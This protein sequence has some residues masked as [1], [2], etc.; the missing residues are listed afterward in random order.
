MPKDNELKKK[1][2]VKKA[3]IGVIGMGYVGLP[4]AMEFATKG[5]VTI[6]FD[7]DAKKISK[8]RTGESYI[9]YISA[10]QIVKLVKNGKL[11]P[12]DDFSKL[13]I[14]DCIIVCV[15]T[16]LAENKEP[17]LGFIISS[18]GQISKNLRKRQLVVLE[19]TTYPGTTRE[20]VMPILEK[21]GLREGLDF[22]LAFSPE[23]VDPGNTKYKFQNIP[24][25]VGGISAGSTETAGLLYGQIVKKVVP[26]SSAEVAESTKMLE[27]TFRAVNIALVNELKMIFEKMGIN[28]WEVIEAS[29][30][31]PYGFMPFYP[32]PGWGGHCIPIDPFYLSWK[33]RGYGI[34]AN[35]IKL[36]GEINT[37]MPYYVMT[38]VEEGL[39]NFKKKIENSKILILGA[40]YKS[41]I[42]DIRESPSVLLIKI[43]ME[44]GADVVYN[45]P[46]IP[47][48]SG[49][50]K[51]SIDMDSVEL[52]RGNLKNADCVIIA[53]AHKCY[54]YKYIYMNSR[55]IV[56]TRNALKDFRDD[57][58]II[59]A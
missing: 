37:N 19:S 55:L 4:L 56:D 32:G 11:V 45:D 13:G 9:K 40:S 22:Y 2:R 27:N 23:R 38:K 36:A 49:M 50:R 43:L 44:K 42:D 29:A 21:T 33:A 46:Y 15:P 30:T 51:H 8:L 20:V 53:T 26:V 34:D 6:G 5:F 1:I 52:N 35:F 17:D 16:P 48:I 24:K 54:D 7:I 31:K 59:K 28:V 12:E 14:C 3:K 39:N 58:K 18:A 25:V 10:G 57:R 47:K 41:D